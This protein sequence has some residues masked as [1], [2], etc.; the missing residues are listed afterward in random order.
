MILLIRKFPIDL[1]S[2]VSGIDCIFKPILTSAVLSV[3]SASL[4]AFV[5]AAAFIASALLG[6]IKK[7][8]A[9]MSIQHIPAIQ[10]TMMELLAS[11]LICLL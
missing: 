9:K 3:K 7:Y 10:M 4:L 8:M 2:A 6:K 1:T 5:F 11:R